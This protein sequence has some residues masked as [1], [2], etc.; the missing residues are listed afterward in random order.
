M[1][2]EG[3]RGGWQAL[4]QVGVGGVESVAAAAEGG[5]LPLVLQRAPHFAASRVPNVR[6]KRAPASD[7]LAAAAISPRAAAMAPRTAAL[8]SA[9]P[10][11]HSVRCASNP[12][13]PLNHRK[14]PPLAASARSVSA[15]AALQR[16]QGTTA[17]IDSTS[18]AGLLRL[19]DTPVRHP[20]PHHY[21]H[22]PNT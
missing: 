10:P 12:V 2:W 19:F 17:A 20:H 5:V 21:P 7:D 13:M 22:L 3:R 11:R 15:A 1:M 14:A 4:V 6:R 8:G 16:K 9:R 18:G